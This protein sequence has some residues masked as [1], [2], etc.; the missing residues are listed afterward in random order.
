MK[1]YLSGGMTGLSYKES[2]EWRKDI[3]EYFDG[4]NVK[5]FNPVEKNGLTEPI[6]SMRYD[7]DK[8]NQA[9]LVIVNFNAQ[10]SIG[11]AF[12]LGYA[13][14]RRIPIIGL[15]ETGERLHTW[16]SS[17]CIHVFTDMNE[18]LDFVKNYYVEY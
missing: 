15:N 1:I 13:Y 14:E 2:N 7:L 12:E 3:Q 18:M 16:L 5:V 4:N 9:D 11:T 6:E 10:N 8:L 17:C